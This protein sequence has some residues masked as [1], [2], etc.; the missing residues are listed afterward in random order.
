MLEKN[1]LYIVAA[2][3]VFLVSV[4]IT[5]CQSEDKI[6][7]KPNIVFV[8]TDDH[9]SHAISAYGSDIIETPNMDRL[10]NEGILFRNAFVTNSI[11]APSRA[12]LLTGKHS[13]V[14]GQL[15]NGQE[16]DG[17]Q[18]TFPK[19][20]QEAGYQTA[21]IGKWHLQSNPTGYDHWDI[22]PGQ[23]HYYNPEFITQERTHQIEGYVT[24]IITDKVI[25][26]ID[27]KQNS[28][29]PFMVSYHHKAPHRNWK[30]HPDD[31]G[32]FDDVK[33]PEP[34]TLFANWSG[35]LTDEQASE[36]VIDVELKNRTSAVE[37]QEMTLMNHFYKGWDLKF[38]PDS[39]EIE[40]RHL[41]LW[42]SRYNR[43]TEEQKAEWDQVFG[44]YYQEY[45]ESELEGAERLSWIYQRYIKD[46][47]STIKSVD[48]NLGR[49]LDYLDEEG[50]ADNTIIIYASDQGFF[51]GDH[52]WYDKRWMYEE[53]LRFPL[54]MRWPDGIEAGIE[55]NDLVQN[56]DLAPTVVDFS[57][58]DAPKEMQGMSLVPLTQNLTPDDWRSS[59]YYHYY[60][61][62]GAHEVQRH[63]GVRTDRYK[64]IHYYQI[65]EW[66][67]F[68]LQKDPNEIQSVYNDSEYSE[69]VNELKAE[70]QLLRDQFQVPEED[71]L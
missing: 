14:N 33:I 1:R 58:L 36:D 52:G 32:M 6:S 34:E 45:N 44:K 42:K 50:L 19:I 41:D 18:L 70:L 68:D 56:I 63:Y 49:L 13:H 16:F 65:D 24:D 21:L 59:I 28:D 25:N 53:S 9:A 4:S 55:N 38:P 46:Y 66:E 23:G 8:F 47:L 10:A 60:E 69:I 7:N 29:Q 11:C 17:D 15:T 20:L 40:T 54:M 26:W 2:A 62:P 57:G 27:D 48:D 37:T 12:V 64:L 39:I 61:F 30:P 22:L 43:F 67:L 71:S 3:L 5:G 51:L 31:L 35:E